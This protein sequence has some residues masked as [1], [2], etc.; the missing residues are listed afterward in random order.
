MSRCKHLAMLRRFV[1]PT[2]SALR[3]F[4]GLLSF[5]DEGMTLP[6]KLR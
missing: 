2:Y 3:T 5:Q 4:L 6:L 1:A